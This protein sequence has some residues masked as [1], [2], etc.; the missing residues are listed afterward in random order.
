MGMDTAGIFSGIGGLELGMRR[1]GHDVGLMCEIDEGAQEVLRTR[2]KEVRFHSDVRSLKSLPRGT[3][4]LTAGF[5][6]QDLS[7]V[8]QTK[9]LRGSESGL[10]R[11]VF[12]L[13][14]RRPIPWVLIENVP[15]MLHLRKGH[16]LRY[17]ISR[18]EELSYRWAYRVID[19]RAFGVPQRRRR[20]Y[21]LASL[22]ADPAEVLLSDDFD[23]PE[24]HHHDGF[25]CGF[26]WT[27][28]TRGLGWAVDAIPPLKGGS[29]I[30]I[31]SPPAIWLPGGQI[32]TPHI[33]DAEALQGFPRGWTASA[34]NRVPARFRWTLI[35]NA[36]TVD[37]ARWIGSRLQSPSKGRAPLWGSRLAKDDS[38]PMAAFGSKAIGRFRVDV[39]TWPVARASD[40]LADFL[41]DDP[42]PLSTKAAEGFLA[43]FRESSLKRPRGFMRAMKTHIKEHSIK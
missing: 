2:F 30:G 26:Y 18:L 35:G 41:R 21:M 9:G 27:E 43:R 1:A 7:Q 5:P 37:V 11:H 32:V 33:R 13:L 25:A 34:E 36:V 23:E 31:P 14:R 40:P 3:E 24:H 38:W 4:L 17:L 28:G 42:A 15:F 8:G 20:V 29:A 16:A 6:C 39:G 19:S 22:E 10:V 12:R